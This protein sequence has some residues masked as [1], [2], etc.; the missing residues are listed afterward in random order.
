M[1]GGLQMDIFFLIIIVV[2]GIALLATFLL[3]RKFTKSITLA[4]KYAE[5]I[6]N[7]D[8]TEDIPKEMLE[9]KGQ[10]GDLARILQKTIENFRN[11]IE[12]SSYIVEQVASSSEELSATI[13][14]TSSA[15]EDIAN[16]I[17]E[18]AKGVS[19][20]AEETENGSIEISELGE[21]I[22]SNSI[23][24]GVLVE[25]FKDI[26]NL[27]IEGSAIL[28]ELVIKTEESNEALDEIFDVITS[29][30][31][32]TGNIENA[33]DMI[34]QIAEQTNLLA[35]NAAIEAARAGEYGKGFAVVAE[36]IRKLAE[37]T[38]EFTDEIQVVIKDLTNK[39]ENA[40][41]S[42]ENV[43][44]LASIQDQSVEMTK[45]RFEGIT[46][47]IEKANEATD[48]LNKSGQAMEIR[49]GEIINIVQ[50]LSAIAQEDAA[51][52]EEA[53][54]SVEEQAASMEEISS[55]SDALASLAEE[56]QEKFSILKL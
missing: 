18:I 22:E 43:S 24:I 21:L 14:Q 6:S 44:E 46:F 26:E 17:E 55:A 27:N 34:G 35:L 20:Q 37:Q 38:N 19:D 9:K 48:A 32:S 33:S 41:R 42:M 7:L 11:F 31:E 49:K 40:V 30:D 8:I 28:D 16:T 56:M 10:I 4:I 47:A 29:V 3:N 25:M 13:E 5:K 15:T 50:N 36:E 53:S 2:L 45:E 52:T 39:T 1:R 12:E 23:D 51:S 54:A